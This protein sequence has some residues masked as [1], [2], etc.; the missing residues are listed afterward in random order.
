MSK[1]YESMFCTSERRAPF[2]P[3]AHPID[4]Q[5]SSL[6]PRTSALANHWIIFNQQN[7][8]DLGYRPR[9]DG[10]GERVATLIN[11]LFWPD[12]AS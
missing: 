1:E 6:R 5:P 10:A 3:V 8:H 7:T 11:L 2:G 9:G 4:R 12:A